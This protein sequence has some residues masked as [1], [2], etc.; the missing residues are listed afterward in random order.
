MMM[1]RD[2]IYQG[3]TFFNKKCWHQSYELEGHL[4]KVQGANIDEG[5]YGYGDMR[6]PILPS[7]SLTPIVSLAIAV[8]VPAP[9]LRRSVQMEDGLRWN[10]IRTR[11]I[12]RI[13][14]IGGPMTS[15]LT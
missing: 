9:N 8:P 11:T 10:V 2:I 7:T 3:Q 1:F 13:I 5:P 15:F 4:F 12:E 6:Y 14:K